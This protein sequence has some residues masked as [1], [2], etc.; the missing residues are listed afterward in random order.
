MLLKY[1]NVEDI[2]IINHAGATGK[3]KYVAAIT[4][5]S[6]VLDPLTY[7]KH[8]RITLQG[9]YINEIR[10]FSYML[11]RAIRDSLDGHVNFF[12]RDYCEFNFTVQSFSEEVADQLMAE[13]L[14]Q[15]H[16]N[17]TKGAKELEADTAE[18]TV[19]KTDKYVL[20]LNLP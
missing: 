19:T 20:L 18:A 16:I 11:Q 14:R 5:T 8:L 13:L 3:S 12:H 6:S 9:D 2:E 17:F 7:V 15:I 1:E 10:A 4:V